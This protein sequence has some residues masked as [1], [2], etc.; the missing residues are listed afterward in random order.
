MIRINLLSQRKSKRVA[1]GTAE[2][3]QQTFAIGL[4]A[5]L[6]A[7]AAV[8]FL[9]DRPLRGDISDLEDSNAKLTAQNGEIEKKLK[10]GDPL[11]GIP[12]EQTIKTAVEGLTKRREAIGLIEQA[13]V[14]PAWMLRDLG[15]ILSLKFNEQPTM[16]EATAAQLKARP[17]LAFKGDEFDPRHVWITGFSEKEGNFK[18][19]GG[20]QSEADITK[21][22][23]RLDASVY[24]DAVT[25][26][27][28]KSEVDKGTGITYYTFTITGK[29]VY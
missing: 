25:A 15:R 4:L 28:G 26:E 5:V 21:L 22:A 19:A 1:G 23:K 6:V 24:F 7:G 2:K 13:A 17:Q 20:S 16:T 10:A 12:P 9:V 8:F 18:L 29:V 27:K 3:G 14:T 11:A